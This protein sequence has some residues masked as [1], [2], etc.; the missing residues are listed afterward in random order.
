MATPGL[1]IGLLPR[2]IIGIAA[3]LAIGAAAAG[4]PAL[5]PV[6][7]LY[8][9]FHSLFGSL[10]TFS[11]PMI[12]LGFIIPGI[13]SVGKGAGKMLPMAVLFA[14]TFTLVA[15]FFAYFTT[16]GVAGIVV[17]ADGFVLGEYREPASPITTIPIAPVMPTMTALVFSF[18]VG[19]CLISFNED[20]VIK[21][22]FGEFR[23]II[24]MY[25]SKVLIPLLPI[26]ISAIF[27]NMAF[28][29]Q[30]GDMVVSFFATFVLI[31]VMHWFFLLVLYGIGGSLF[32]K[33]PLAL[34]KKM[35]P[36]YMT[37]VGT[38]SSA[39]TI[40]VNLINVKRLGVKEAVADMVVPL[41]ATINLP[42]STMSIVACTVVVM[43]LYG[44]EVSL[45]ILVPYIFALSILMIAAPGVP[46]GA[47]VAAFA[48]LEGVLGFDEIQLGVMAA[49]YFAQDSL[50]TAVNVTSDGAMSLYINRLLGHKQ[51][52]A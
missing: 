15:G 37:A 2:L 6:M 23:Q 44:M 34:L 41:G 52:E 27:A 35:M 38:M 33:S 13:Y 10:L 28:I 39:A 9:T 48:A 26:H 17:G 5:Y 30:A 22:F 14:A 16:V 29:G 3:G 8:A 42:G 40:P 51:L 46:G 11:I 12:I 47:I 19:I 24:S 20:S 18:V 7:V 21:R 50:G 49:L 36:S 1:K 43:Y 25:V 32:G 4:I 31:I 45:A